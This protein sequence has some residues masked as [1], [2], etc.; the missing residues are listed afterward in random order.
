MRNEF[1]IRSSETSEEEVNK[2]EFWLT[3]YKDGRIDLE[4]K[5]SGCCDPDMNWTILSVN[6]SGLIRRYSGLEKTFVGTDRI[7]EE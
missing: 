1:S 2:I 3:Q 7:Q 4:F 5:E 6:Q